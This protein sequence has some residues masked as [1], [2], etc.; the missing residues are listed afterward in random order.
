MT[1]EVECDIVERAKQL[2]ADE[3]L[4][5]TGALTQALVD[6]IERLRRPTPRPYEEW[7]EHD[8][9]VVW[10][11]FP[12]DEAP[13]VGTPF[14]LGHTVNV[15]IEWVNGAEEMTTTVGGWPGY[16]THWTPLPMAGDPPPEPEPAT[17]DKDC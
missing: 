5:L 10:W 13:Y 4:P 3:C 1:E 12:I 15:S 17:A 11:K 14:D 16:H 7:A 9:P 8:G 6:E 2:I